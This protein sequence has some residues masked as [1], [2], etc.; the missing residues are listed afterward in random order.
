METTHGKALAAFVALNQIRGMVKGMDALHVYHMKNRLKESVD[1]FSEEE[2]RLVNEAGGI[3]TENGTVL[4]PDKEKRKQYIAERKALDELPCEIPAEP[5]T[6]RIDRCP[7]VTAE[8]IELLAGFV[9]FEE[10]HDDGNK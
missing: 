3:V 2:M 6:I 5:I 1:F 9:I 8:Q 7:D 4:I 10:G